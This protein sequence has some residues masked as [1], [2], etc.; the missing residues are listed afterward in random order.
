MLL[1]NGVSIETVSVMLGH[2][3]TTTTEKHYCR[4]TDDSA[5]LEVIQA[6]QSRQVNP[7]KLTPA[8]EL[9]G[10]A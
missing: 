3:S 7:A 1:N 4:K 2:N 9:P 6:M 5:R 8:T 10:Y